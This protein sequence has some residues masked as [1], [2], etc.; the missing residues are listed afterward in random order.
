MTKII[1]EIITVNKLYKLS[2]LKEKSPKAIPS[3]HIK[4]IF[5]NFDVYNSVDEFLILKL[6]T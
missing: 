1:I 3:F 2:W 6:I 5:K 4:F